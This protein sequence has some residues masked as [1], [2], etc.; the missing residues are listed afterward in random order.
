MTNEVLNRANDIIGG[1]KWANNI[2]N[3]VGNNRRFSFKVDTTRECVESHEIVSCPT[4]LRDEICD[5]VRAKKKE[6]Q[7]EFAEL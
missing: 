2:L 1:I 5:V 6:W 4:W 7:E 3:H